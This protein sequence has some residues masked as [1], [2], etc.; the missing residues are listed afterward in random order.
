MSKTML[1]TLLCAGFALTGCNTVEGFGKD[2]ERAGGSIEE[3]AQEH[4]AANTKP[5]PAPK[6]PVRNRTVVYR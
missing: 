1:L 3:S 6:K 2:M 4:K 5:E